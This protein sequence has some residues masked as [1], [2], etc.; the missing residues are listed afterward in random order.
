[1]P[2]APEA[3]PSGREALSSAPVAFSLVP[4]VEAFC[5]GFRLGKGAAS[6]LDGVVTK[7]ALTFR[8]GATMDVMKQGFGSAVDDEDDDGEMA[9]LLKAGVF[10]AERK[11]FIGVGVALFPA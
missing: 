1:M 11:V 9:V 8:I 6:R 5:A 10:A 3:L 4:E 7:L 2:L